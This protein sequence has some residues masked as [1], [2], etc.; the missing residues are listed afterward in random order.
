MFC[1]AEISRGIG[2]RSSVASL[3]LTGTCVVPLL[4]F[5]SSRSNSKRKKFKYSQIPK[6]NMVRKGVT[7]KEK[8]VRLLKS[9]IA[10]RAAYSPTL[11][12]AQVYA[13][14]V[15][16]LEAL[17]NYTLKSKGK[18]KKLSTQSYICNK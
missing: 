11:E 10:A 14:V 17:F 3:D 7:A 15:S 12:Y 6:S 16:E 8:R 18:R 13:K 1:C 2:H 9:K 4:C 5:R